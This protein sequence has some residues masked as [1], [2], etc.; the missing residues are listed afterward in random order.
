MG[1][2]F[3]KATFDI[4]FNSGIDD[5]NSWLKLLKD[6]GLVKQ[7]GAYYTIVNKSTAEE[8]RFMAKDWKTMLTE[9]PALKQQCYEEICN[10]I[11]MKYR[12]QEA[13]DPDQI[14]V[15]DE[16]LSE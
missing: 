14:S 9:D 11:I 13:I 12:D 2:P 5:L 15:D 16:E 8:V 7:G 3:K 6:Y 4:Y 1:P 10:T